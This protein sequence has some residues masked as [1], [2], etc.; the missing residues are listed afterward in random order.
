MDSESRRTAIPWFVK[1]LQ[2]KPVRVRLVVESE[3]PSKVLETEDGDVKV[4]NWQRLCVELFPG[5]IYPPGE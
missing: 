3:P 2:C 5:D 4:R 1:R